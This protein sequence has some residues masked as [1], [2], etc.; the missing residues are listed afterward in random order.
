MRLAARGRIAAM[1]SL[2]ALALLTVTASAAEAPKAAPPAR[3][4][5]L[6]LAHVALFVHDI[7]AARAFYKGYLGYD[8]P[9]FLNTPEGALHLTWIKINERQSLELFP[10]KEAGSDRLN[11]VAVETD[12]AE[13]LRAYLA[14][15]GVKVPDKVGKGRI[16]NSNF[17]IP[18]PDGHGFEIVQYEPDGWT[19][20]EKG[21]FLPEGRISSRMRHAGIAVGDLERSLAFYRDILGFKETWRGSRD[22]KTLSWV[23]LQV[24]DGD[25]YLELMLYETLPAPD[26]RGTM[27]HVCLEVPDVPA[28]WAL[29]EKRTLPKG[30]KLP[31]PMKTGT[32]GKRQINL[33]DPDGTR[34]EIMEPG[35]ADGK[36]VPPSEAPVPRPTSK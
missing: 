29:V 22:G 30:S 18:D 23:N 19:V 17:T 6:G 2:V 5:I 9:Y 26:A 24:P 14:F 11:H 7:D 35:T 15:R 33:Y 10:E 20:R 16:G 3:P 34:V 12:D 4:R 27:H 8:E 36:P 21:K 25:E 32:N 13:A 31:T 1:K 28:A